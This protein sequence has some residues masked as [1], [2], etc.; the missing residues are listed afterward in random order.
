MRRHALHWTTDHH[1]ISGVGNW[2]T[3]KCCCLFHVQ[4]EVRPQTRFS[5]FVF[6]KCW[7][8]IFSNE[9]TQPILSEFCLFHSFLSLS[10]SLS[11]TL[12]IS[13]SLSI[14][15]NFSLSLLIIIFLYRSLYLSLSFSLY[16]TLSSLLL[17]LA[18]LSHSLSISLSRARA[19]SLSLSLYFSGHL[20]CARIWYTICLNSWF[21]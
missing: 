8:V 12:S 10:L 20:F 3:F 5:V 4:Q 7:G 18:F 2:Y 13:L 16:F 17:P 15:L 14:S 19:L 21:M 9:R 6:N 11:P 1:S